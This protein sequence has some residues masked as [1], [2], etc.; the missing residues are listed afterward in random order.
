LEVSLQSNNTQ[1]EDHPHVVNI[2]RM[3]NN[4]DHMVASRVVGVCGGNGRTADGQPVGD[5]VAHSFLCDR[6]SGVQGASMAREGGKIDDLPEEVAQR[7]DDQLGRIDTDL[8][9]GG[10]NAA[11][12]N[13]DN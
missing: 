8:I 6:W 10:L 12:R 9:T 2:R 7:L 13:D 3:V 4:L 1:G 11:D 5:F